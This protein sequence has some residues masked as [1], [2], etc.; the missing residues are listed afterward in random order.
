MDAL[1]CPTCGYGNGP[2]ALMCAMCSEVLKRKSGSHR[3][4]M[5]AEAPAAAPRGGSPLLNFGSLE[6][7]PAERP[8]PRPSPYAAPGPAVEIPAG[9]RPDDITPAK[10]K[11]WEQPVFK[12]RSGRH[13]LLVGFVI[14]CLFC[15]PFFLF[16]SIGWVFES[17][18]HEMGHTLMAY[19]M[20]S[21]ALPA[22]RLDGHAAT[23]HL[24][25]WPLLA[26]A[27]WAMLLVGAAF[28]GLAKHKSLFITLGI[29]AVLY[30]FFAF[31]EAKEFLHL[32]SGHGGEL[33]IAT[34]FF[35][36]SMVPGKV[37]EEERTLYASLAWYLWFQNVFLTWNLVFSEASRDW[38]LENGSFGLE[39]DLVRIADSFGWN[40]P[41]L[42]G[43]MLIFCLSVPPLGLLWAHW[44]RKHTRELQQ[45][46]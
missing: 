15:L 18:V 20:G 40:L 35:W 14:A 24:D 1:L 26:F 41:L 17:V 30:P 32:I 38:Y 46:G 33:V 2:Q 43:L 19:F 6:D 13:H 28:F 45:A 25:Q 29:L 36:R 44:T 5:P 37:L 12:E 23:V 7:K 22:L 4:S 21:I 34:I 11:S 42:A 9:I 16:R 10:M 3:E 8:E 27:V 31:T 39:N